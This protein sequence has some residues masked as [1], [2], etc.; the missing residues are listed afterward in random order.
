MTFTYYVFL[1]FYVIF[2]GFHLLNSSSGFNP[3]TFLF[4]IFI[5]TILVCGMPQGKDACVHANTQR[6]SRSRG[7][8]F[9]TLLTTISNMAPPNIM[10]QINDHYAQLMVYNVAPID[11]Y[12]LNN[13]LYLIHL[14]VLV[15]SKKI[16]RE[17]FEGKLR[18]IVGDNIII[19]A[20]TILQ[21]KVPNLF[22][23]KVYFC[24][25]V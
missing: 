8:P 9:P 11:S 21:V 23:L 15:Q 18:L 1:V 6:T 4:I 22:I 19:S 24:F 17:E 7:I 10:Y 20:L 16:S 5:K 2:S 3:I 13:E 14:G 25:D 12:I